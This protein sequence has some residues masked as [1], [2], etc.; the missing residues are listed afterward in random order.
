M[1]AVKIGMWTGSLDALRR[2]YLTPYGP[3]LTIK[4][5]FVEDCVRV[6]AT[7]HTQFQQHNLGG[8]LFDKAFLQAYNDAILGLAQ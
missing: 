4:S 8:E 2:R 7:L 3:S 5:A 6:E 1:D